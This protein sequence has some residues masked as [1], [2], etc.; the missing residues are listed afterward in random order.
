M[1]YRVLLTAALICFPAT[2]MADRPDVEPGLWKTTSTIA[3]E[4]PMEM[5][6]RTETAEQC[7][8][9]EDLD[10]EEI[11]LFEETEECEITEV[12]IERSG[13]RYQMVCEQEG[14]RMEA[15][16][17]FEFSGNRTEGRIVAEMEGPMG[18]MKTETTIESERI[19]DC[20]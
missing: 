11:P 14:M 15:E 17:Q 10:R 13:M 18:R 3:F 6:D 16:A 20:P 12:E 4:G 1:T 19:G 2:A 8:T 7:I 5:P 9:E